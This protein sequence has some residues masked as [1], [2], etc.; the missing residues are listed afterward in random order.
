[1][2]KLQIKILISNDEDQLRFLASMYSYENNDY[3]Y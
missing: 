1:M 3:C 2:D